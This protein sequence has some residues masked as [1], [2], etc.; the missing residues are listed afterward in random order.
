MKRFKHM[1]T[2]KFVQRRT[3]S[4]RC[5]ALLMRSTSRGTLLEGYRLWSGYTCAAELP[6]PATW[7]SDPAVSPAT[8]ITTYRQADTVMQTKAATENIDSS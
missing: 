2:F 7:R 3:W 8:I 4:A 1:Q 5:S 6:S